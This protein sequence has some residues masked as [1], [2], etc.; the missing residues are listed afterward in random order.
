MNGA[1]NRGRTEVYLLNKP[2]FDS[3]LSLNQKNAGM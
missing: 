2:R 3:Y 1:I